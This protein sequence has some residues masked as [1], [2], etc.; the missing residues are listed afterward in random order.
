MW[1]TS[2]AIIL[3]FWI[4]SLCFLFLDLTGSLKRYKVQPGKNEPIEVR[5]LIEVIVKVPAVCKNK[6]FNPW[7]FQAIFTVLFNQTVVSITFS[8]GSFWLRRVLL[9]ELD[10]R[11]NVP[12]FPLLMRDLLIAHQVFDTGFFLLHRLMHTKYFYKRI[13]KIHH[14]WK[15]PIGIIAIYAHPTGNVS[16]LSFSCVFDSF[17]YCRTFNNELDSCHSWTCLNSSTWLHNLDLVFNCCDFNS[18]WPLWLPF[19]ISKESRVSW[20]SSRQLYWMFWYL[21]RDGFYIQN[22]HKIPAVN[23]LSKTSSF[24]F[25]KEYNKRTALKS[26]HNNM[27]WIIF[28]IFGKQYFIEVNEIHHSTDV[29]HVFVF[30]E[31]EKI[32]DLIFKESL[33]EIHDSSLSITKSKN[34]LLINHFI[35]KL[36]ISSFSPKPEIT[37]S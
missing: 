22:R 10:A 3:V 28:N 31:I 21:R 35:C 30:S 24:A 7:A 23:Q 13:H 34:V 20:S 8:S 26:R 32:K 12:S 17:L 9:G 11:E 36:F 18:F 4:V 37:N 25:F 14:E 19:T 2:G 16:R 5:K 1:A 29:N 33:K 6:T 27:R 15:A